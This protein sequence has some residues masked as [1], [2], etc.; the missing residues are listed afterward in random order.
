MM[1][2]TFTGRAALTCN[3]KATRSDY[4]FIQYNFELER[5]QKKR[6]NPFKNPAQKLEWIKNNPLAVIVNLLTIYREVL[7]LTIYVKP[8][9]LWELFKTLCMGPVVT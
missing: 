4:N 7:P 5:I 3:K 2:S 9:T 8:I 6:G 1:C